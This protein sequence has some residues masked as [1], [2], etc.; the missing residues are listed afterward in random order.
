VPT[1]PAHH[2]HCLSS[3]AVRSVITLPSQP[4]A[5]PAARAG[6]AHE[7]RWLPERWHNIA[8]PIT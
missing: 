3:S 1:S 8:E 6:L 2:G 4:S 5:A 7:R